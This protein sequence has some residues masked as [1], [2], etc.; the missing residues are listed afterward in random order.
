MIAGL[1]AR[2]SC[3]TT[4]PSTGSRAGRRRRRRTRSREARQLTT[5]H[6][7]WLV[8]ARVPAA[9]SSARRWSTTSSPRPPVLPPG[10]GEAF[11][12]V[13]FQG[14]AYR[15]GHSMVRP[16]YR[17]NLAGDDGNPFFGFIFDPA[18]EGQA[19]P[20]D[21]RGGVRAP[22]R[23]IGWQTFFDFGDG[24]VKP[25]K[26]ID[27]K[28]LDAAVQPAAGAIA[29]HDQ[30]AVAAAA[31]PAA[32]PHLEPAVRPGDRPGDGRARRSR[33]TDLLELKPY[34]TSISSTPLWYYVL[35]EAELL[36]DGLHLGPV[37]GRIVA[38]VL[39]GLLQTDPS[40]YLRCSPRWTPTLQ[41]PG[42]RRLP[43]D[44]LPDLRRRR[45][46]DPARTEPDVRLIWRW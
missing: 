32:A 35:K 41:N 19:D 28:H 18:G 17:A 22:R 7:Q 36:E 1:H 24:E 16:S 33:K 6:Y 21:L 3:S 29:S 31:Q 12:P 27:T 11:I 34:R 10:A 30:P 20:V 43:D 37:G 44:R 40:S 38:E 26:R 5:W 23:F 9:R 46:G 2:S 39:I 8:A 25:N 4:G 13:E 14:A 15:F 42:R 45:P